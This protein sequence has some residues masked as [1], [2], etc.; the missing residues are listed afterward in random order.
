MLKSAGMAIKF[1]AYSVRLAGNPTIS[2][3]AALPVRLLDARR[4]RKSLGDRLKT[5]LKV[6]LNCVS[7]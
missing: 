7:D 4:A 6:R 2:R 5:R 1:I 3:H